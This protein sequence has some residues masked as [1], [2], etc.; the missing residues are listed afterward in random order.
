MSQLRGLAGPLGVTSD[1][2]RRICLRQQRLHLQPCEPSALLK[3][4]PSDA[5]HPPRGQLHDPRGATGAGQELQG[6]SLR[7]AEIEVR[8]ELC[9]HA[10][11]Q[12]LRQSVQGALC[13]SKWVTR[14]RERK[15]VL[16]VEILMISWLFRGPGAARRKV[17]VSGAEELPEDS[18][19]DKVPEAGAEERAGAILRV[20]QRQ[21]DVPP[22]TP[23]G[24]RPEIQFQ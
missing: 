15:K 24:M 3:R 9:L 18:V 21:Q 8:G 12:D 5:G 1:G 19:F 13:E 14:E 11:Q 22:P 7:R 4:V 2:Q 6:E 17:R 23:L 10:V 16:C 20:R